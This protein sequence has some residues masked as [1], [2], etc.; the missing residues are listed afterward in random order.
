MQLLR[1]ARGAPEGSSA[2]CTRCVFLGDQP[3]GSPARIPGTQAPLGNGRT[4]LV[5]GGRAPIWKSSARPARHDRDQRQC[6]HRSYRNELWPES[7]PSAPVTRRAC[8]TEPSMGNPRTRPAIEKRPQAH[9][10][11]D[12]CGCNALE[13]SGRGRSVGSQAQAS[14]TSRPSAY[15]MKQSASSQR[16]HPPTY[17][18]PGRRSA[19]LQYTSCNHSPC[20]TLWE[21]CV[22][23]HSSALGLAEP[24]SPSP[25][26]RSRPSRL[27]DTNR[28]QHPIAALTRL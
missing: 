1:G 25:L 14:V 15:T 12:Q 27:N 24:P 23:T 2:V 19:C 21:R 13:L 5:C 18:T 16:R 6:Q 22:S 4:R 9:A 3:S 28:R 8:C 7:E 20:A 10:I 11:P 17:G 26:A